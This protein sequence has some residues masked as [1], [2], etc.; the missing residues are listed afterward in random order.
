MSDDQSP[1]PSGEPSA[2]DL[3]RRTLE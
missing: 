3:V 2:M 1:S